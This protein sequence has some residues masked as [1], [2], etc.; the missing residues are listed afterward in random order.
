MGNVLIPFD[1]NRGYQALSLHSGLPQQEVADRIRLSGLYNA[2]ESGQIETEEFLDR[3]SSL[4]GLTLS[5]DAFREVWNS[6]FLPHTATSEELI[7][8]L[9]QN[10]RLV[11]LSNTNELHY[12]WLRE[13]YPILHHFDAYTLS[14]AEK[15][16]KPDERIF[17]AAVSYAQCAPHE[18]FFTDDIDRYVDAA[19][20]FGIDAEIFTTE[21][22]LRRH[23]AARG[24]NFSQNS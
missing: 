12:H 17:A 9:K 20:L 19:R 6:I 5:F 7:L 4:L 13:R 21:S 14:Y 11:L 8:S 15:A 22:T 23:L 18:C 2:Y 16:M 24:L 10:H 1:I 3:F